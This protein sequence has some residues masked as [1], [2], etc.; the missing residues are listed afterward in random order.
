M[1]NVRISVS[2]KKLEPLKKGIRS[3]AKKLLS[4]SNRRHSVLEIYLVDSRFMHTD[5]LSFPAP[6]DFPRPDV[7]GEFLGEIYLNPEY[8]KK[9]REDVFFMLTHGFLHLLGYNHKK[10][11]DRIKMENKEKQL[12]A[13][14]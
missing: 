2:G 3:A 9:A 13:K 8:I 14:L 12:F 7:N 4:A 6:K 5:V 10:R 1:A 11:N